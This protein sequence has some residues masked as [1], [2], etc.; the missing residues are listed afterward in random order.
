MLGADGLRTRSSARSPPED[1]AVLHA[2]EA[3][4][5]ALVAAPAAIGDTIAI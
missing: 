2:G 3:V 5:S 4:V 1:L